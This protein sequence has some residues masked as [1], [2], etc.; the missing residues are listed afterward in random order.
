MKRNLTSQAL[1]AAILI[2]AT[3]GTGWAGDSVSVPWNEVCRV[4]G[5]RELAITTQTG[6]TVQGYC[7]S[8]NV[9]EI[10][11][12]GQNGRIVK[13]ARSTLERIRVRR[14]STP[15]HAM[16]SLGKRV[17]AGLGFSFRSL[18]TPEAPLGIIILPGT[19]A[20]GAAATPFCLLGDFAYWIGGSQEIKVT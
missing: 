15:G 4:A 17:G 6:E 18:L 12:A 1:R 5:V 9:T 13:I 20:Y 3:M 14:A 16:A 2:G 8:I 19:L 11:V 7:R 10:A